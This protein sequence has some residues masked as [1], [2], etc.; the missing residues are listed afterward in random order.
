MSDPASIAF[1]VDDD[2]SI[3]DALASLIRSV[4]LKVE[5]F[6]SAREFLTHQRPDAPA[7]LVL[8]VRLPGLSG[9]DLQRELAEAQ[10]ADRCRIGHQRNHDQNAPWPGHAQDA[11]RV[12]RGPCQD[13]REIGHPR[14]RVL[15]HLYQGLI[16]FP[17]CTQYLPLRKATRSANTH[18]VFNTFP[19]RHVERQSCLMSKS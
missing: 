5:A 3:R 18:D 2:P 19:C 1:V 16:A 6:R 15:T 7:C 13:G 8:D 14:H 10:K 17:P 9:L 4:A 12:A 11:R